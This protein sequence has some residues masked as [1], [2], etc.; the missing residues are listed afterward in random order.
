VKEGYVQ[1]STLAQEGTTFDLTFSPDKQQQ[2]IYVPDGVNKKVQILSRDTL[3][4]IGF[5]GG[6]GGRGFGEFF[7]IHSITSDSKGNIY[8]GESFGQRVYRYN[9]KGM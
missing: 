1:R 7:H 4:V 9:Y 5:F 6:R 2:F 8:L 3:E